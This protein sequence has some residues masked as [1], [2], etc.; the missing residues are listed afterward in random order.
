[1]KLNELIDILEINRKAVSEAKIKVA[2]LLS[3]R[4]EQFNPKLQE[5]F[6]EAINHIS[7]MITS[8]YTGI[9][10]NVEHV[11]YHD[12]NPYFVGP[13]G[14]REGY[15]HESELSFCSGILN[16]VSSEMEKLG[17][18]VQVLDRQTN[19]QIK[20]KKAF[21]DS[22]ASIVGDLLS[23]S[24]I[25]NADSLTKQSN[26]LKEKVE[27]EAAK[28]AEKDRLT[29]EKAD[30]EAKVKSDAIAKEQAEEAKAEEDRLAKEKADAEAEAKTEADRIE[31]ENTA[32]AVE[33][34]ENADKDLEVKRLD[35]EA[36][37]AE[38]EIAKSNADIEKAKADTAKA[39]STKAKHEADKV[40]A[41]AAKLKAEA[42]IATAKK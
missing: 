22:R 8:A 34:K 15:Q 26:K 30:A 21:K 11:P 7:K 33:A 20:L 31:K 27:A 23:I 25:I 9:K 6:D 10:Y 3:L 42:K 36:K 13:I 41:E 35:V 32:A 2:N 17:D 38:A 14:L 37:K 18:L 12:D 29:K 19:E 28:K 40:K 4:G 5:K 24:K 1:M 16:I 39:D